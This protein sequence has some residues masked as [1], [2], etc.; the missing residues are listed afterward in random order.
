MLRHFLFLI[1][2]LALGLPDG[3]RHRQV[4]ADQEQLC[5]GILDRRLCHSHQRQRWTGNVPSPGHTILLG[6]LAV[7]NAIYNHH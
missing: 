5:F 6:P 4:Q 1:S 3:F 2:G 7:T